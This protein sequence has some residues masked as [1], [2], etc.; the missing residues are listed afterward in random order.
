MG[1]WTIRVVPIQASR[2]WKEHNRLPPGIVVFPDQGQLTAGADGGVKLDSVHTPAPP[3]TEGKQVKGLI[4]AALV[5]GIIA[6]G[7]LIIGTNRRA[8]SFVV[9]G[10]GAW[11]GHTTGSE[12]LDRSQHGQSINPIQDPSARGLWLSLAADTAGMGAFAS[13]AALARIASTEGEL[14]FAA[15]W[16]L[17]S[18]KVIANATNGAAF[19]SAGPSSIMAP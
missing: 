1:M 11:Q 7:A 16:A 12:L 9:V 17:G 8:T 19:A 14:G 5:G 6:G 10:S 15:A 18:A 3:D 2:H 4:D 13:E